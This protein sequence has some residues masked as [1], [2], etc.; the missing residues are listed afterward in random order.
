MVL[1]AFAM[2]DKT[3][4]GLITFEDVKT[5]FDVSGSPDFA[6]RRLTKDQIVS[7]FMNSF[8]GK[9]GNKDGVITLEEFLDYYSDV[10]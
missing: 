4:D 1:K 6:E 5:L 7:N 2:L 10:S 9:H 8:E 3:G